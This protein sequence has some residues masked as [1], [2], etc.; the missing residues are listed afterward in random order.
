M[1]LADGHHCFSALVSHQ[2]IGGR[3]AH[4]AALA[5]GSACPGYLE[6]MPIRIQPLPVDEHNELWKMIVAGPSQVHLARLV[7]GKR[8]DRDWTL[9]A[10]PRTAL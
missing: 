3:P 1:P 7:S 10:L 9:A 8:G 5:R 4:R 6:Y 2:I